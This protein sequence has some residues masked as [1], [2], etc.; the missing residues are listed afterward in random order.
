MR[1]L[2]M[3]EVECVT[4]GRSQKGSEVAMS[5]SSGDVGGVGGGGGVNIANLPDT[6]ITGSAQNPYNVLDGRFG[7]LFYGPSPWLFADMPLVRGG[8]PNQ[9]DGPSVDNG[10]AATF[11]VTDADIKSAWAYWSPLQNFIGGDGT[12]KS[13][14]LK[15]PVSGETIPALGNSGRVSDADHVIISSGYGADRKEGAVHGGIDYVPYKFD[16]TVATDAKA[17]SITAGTV[18]LVGTV[19]GFGSHTVVIRNSDHGAYITYGHMSAADVKV[20]SVVNVGTKLG[21]IG[22][23]GLNSGTHLHIQGIYGAAFAN[24]KIFVGFVDPD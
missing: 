21:T 16:G 18:V 6:F 9:V 7:E 2:T 23:E 8:A 3:D 14:I 17:L 20:G 4:G 10:T 12:S 24:D 19:N 11:N 1:A 22:S 13:N 15:D 5:E